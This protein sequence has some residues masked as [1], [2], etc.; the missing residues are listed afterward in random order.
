MMD[1]GDSRNQRG[2][3]GR[4][5]RRGRRDDVAH[6]DSTTGGWWAGKPGGKLAVVF[7]IQLRKDCKFQNREDGWLVSFLCLR[8][9]LGTSFS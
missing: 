2:E 1:G 4:R 5:G 6:V 7:K 3:G 9:S 8:A